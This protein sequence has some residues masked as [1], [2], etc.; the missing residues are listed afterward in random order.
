MRFLRRLIFRIV[1]FFSPPLTTLPKEE[2]IKIAE[3]FGLAKEV[4]FA[5]SKG[6]T[7]EQALDEWDLPLSMKEADDFFDSINKRK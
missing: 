4:E 1:N 7:P 5:I 2:A 3:R 6:D